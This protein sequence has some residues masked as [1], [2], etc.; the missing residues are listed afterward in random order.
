LW[1]NTARLTQA[2]AWF[3]G[4]SF[5]PSSGDH[6]AQALYDL[7]SGTTTYTSTVV[8]WATR[9][10]MPASGIACDQCR[11]DGEALILVYD[12][13]YQN[14]TP[15]Q[16]NTLISNYN[17][18][19]IHWM[20]Q[21]WGGPTM[22]QSNYF[23][24]YLRNECEWGITSYGDNTGPAQTFLDECLATRWSNAFV[25]TTATGHNAAGG[26]PQEGDEY[27]RY[28]IW[29]PLVPFITAGLNGRDVYS[30]AN[31]FFEASMFNLIYS[32]SQEQIT[33]VGGGAHWEIF[34][35]S[36]DENFVN[37]GSAEARFSGI[38]GNGSYTGDFMNSMANH[39][40]SVTGQYAKQWLINLGLPVANHVAAVDN[41]S[42]IAAR[43]FSNLALDYYDA[44][45]QYFYGHSAWG[46][47]GTTDFMLQMGAPSG[48][49][50]GHDDYGTWQSR[51][52]GS[53]TAYWLSR[54]TVGYGEAYMPYANP[55]P[56]VAMTAYPINSRV[57]G[58]PSNGYVYQQV[59]NVTC[60]TGSSQP[61]LP[62]TPLA[63]VSDGT[64]TWLNTSNGVS[65][66]RVPVGDLTVHNGI[67][68][69]GAGLGY[70][71]KDGLPV[72]NRLESQGSYSYAD[73]DLT[74][75]YRNTIDTSH[76]E[77]DNRSAGHIEREFV[78]VRSLETMVILD[79]LV[80]NSVGTLPATAIT[81]TFI[82]HCEIN[83]TLEDSNHET[84]TNGNQALRISTLMP[85]SFSQRVVN[86]SSCPNAKS[87]CNTDGQYRLEIDTSGTAQ[88][89][90]LN[91]LQAR[92]SSAAN[93]MASAVDSNPIDPT[94][95]TLTVTLHPS[96][97]SDTTLVFNKT[98]CAVGP[99][100]CSL[101]GTINIAGTG[102]VNLR[103]NVQGISY[104]DNGPVWSN[105]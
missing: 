15:G 47:S 41:S 14:L 88:Q 59:A 65:G 60:I 23:W 67:L 55:Q 80:A 24:G 58:S 31:K 16:K 5:T 99:R 51:R 33:H 8:D 32:T 66:D 46:A 77:R 91:V 63:T 102:L 20:S 98:A 38:D 50:H 83:W 42:G 73:V 18:W 93:L 97:G 92:D 30:D 76:P 11:W 89:Y 35:F 3:S 36:D 9:Y 7:L 85:V 52:N 75:S 28:M 53:S 81:K 40:S 12:W 27:G 87:A 94:S 56:W 29:Y 79:R 84:C 103:T 71:S 90:F 25:P 22:P 19:I 95:G 68:M 62:T 2:K 57:L 49:G 6:M 82:A 96:V 61:S 1:F 34:P 48:V 10:N 74:H 45:I 70:S 86:E 54:E 26:L 78:F 4:H 13:E 105:Q 43:P 69:N 21:S 39:Y 37:G 104:T 17:S 72:V 101:G 100:Q 44:G 64:C